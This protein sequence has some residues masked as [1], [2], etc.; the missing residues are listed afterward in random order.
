LV[1]LSS[2]SVTIDDID[3]SKIGL[4]DLRK[5]LAIIPQDPLLFSG[6]LRSNL[7]PFNLHDDATLWDALK[8]SYLVESTN[9]DSM[10]TKE[11]AP[12]GTHTPVSRFGLDTIIEDE[13]GNLSVGQ[14]SLVSL[15]RALVKNAKIIILDEA[16]ASVDY[17][18]D[19]KI[20]DTIAY[21]FED[22][23]ILCIAHRLRTIISYDRICV[24]DAGQI[25]EF[26]T[27]ANLFAISD[28]IFRGMCERSAITLDDIKLAAKAKTGEHL[29]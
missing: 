20:Q 1:E 26:D 23:T 7:D 21:E 5:A 8:R 15:A 16:T 9:R 17:E 2:G 12:N 19:R 10:I 18:T 28:G 13:G 11:E 6:T 27:P 4:A 29:M 3:V 14:R 25:A 24:L 22:R